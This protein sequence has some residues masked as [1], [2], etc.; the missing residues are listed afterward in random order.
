MGNRF[1]APEP[2]RIARLRSEIIA[3]IPCLTKHKA[4]ARKSLKS[5]RSVICSMPI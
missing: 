1:N 5:Y 4:E 3:A 2:P